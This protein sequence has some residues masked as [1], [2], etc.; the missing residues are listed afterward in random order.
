MAEIDIDKLVAEATRKREAALAKARRAKKIVEAFWFTCL[1][2]V[3]A[4]FV[5]FGVLVFELFRNRA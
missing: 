3:L 4:C 1:A 2:V 5:Y